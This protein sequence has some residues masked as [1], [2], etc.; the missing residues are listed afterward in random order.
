MQLS[1]DS[2][3]VTMSLSRTRR[4][5]IID[6]LI[7]E[8][9]IDLYKQSFS[10]ERFARDHGVSRQSIY[11]YLDTLVNENVLLK[12]LTTNISVS[13]TEYR[14]S[15]TWYRLRYPIAGLA[16]DVV[17]K[18]DIFPAL[19]DVPETALRVCNYAFCEMLN[20]VIDHSEGTRVKIDLYVNAFRSSFL[21]RDDGVGIFT[22]IATAMNLAEKRF[23]ILELAKGKFTTAPESHT[24]EGIFF[25]AKAADVFEIHN[26]SIVFSTSVFDKSEHKHFYIDDTLT[27]GSTT[28]RFDVFHQHVTPLSELFSL[29]ANDPDDYGFTKTIVPVKL[30]EHGDDNPLLV[31][32]SQAK[33]LLVRFDRFE[34][35]ELDF[36]GIDEIG[37]GFADEIFRVYHNQHPGITIVPVNCNSQVE[38]MI[39]HVTSNFNLL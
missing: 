36:A 22:K 30:L 17:W 6:A 29:Y 19:Q 21:I 24:G 10:V 26:D 15:D 2:G 7:N 1:N 18:Q 37:Q 39:K 13:K 31:S 32:R 3:V 20:N 34:H 35:I 28:I 8:L 9:G 27:L 11:R 5:E 25:S 4:K 14:M 16:E 12:Q 33:R 23:A 38:K